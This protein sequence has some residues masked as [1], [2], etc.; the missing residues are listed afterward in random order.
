[1]EDVSTD[2]AVE[3]PPSEV[4][5]TDRKLP[6]LIL[7]YQ[8]QQGEA[9]IKSLKN[10]INRYTPQEEKLKMIYTGTK[11]RSNFNIKDNLNLKMNTT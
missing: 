9:I 7:P 5:N 8:G 3:H 1:M 4:S 10:T 2:T 6:L 11:L